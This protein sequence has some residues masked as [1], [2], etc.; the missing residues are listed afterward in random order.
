MDFLNAENVS[1]IL[2]FI[3][4]MGIIIRKNMMYVII[5]LTIIDAAIILFF[6]NIN[7]HLIAEIPNASDHLVVLVDPFPH[8]LMITSVVIGVAVKAVILIM[9]LQHYQRNKTLD[10]DIARA[11]SENNSMI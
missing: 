8:A 7:N 2:F 4:L 3:G 1:I 6:I 9:M 11:I 5:G 10:W